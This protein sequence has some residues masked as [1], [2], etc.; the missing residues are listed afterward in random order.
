MNPDH[1]KKY[2]IA[3][4]RVE[5]KKKFYQH[6]T[7]YLTMCIFFMGLAFFTKIGGRWI[8]FPILG[9]GIGILS[10]YFKAFGL[11]GVGPETDWEERA[12]EEELRRLGVPPPPQEKTTETPPP[13][14]EAMTPL[15]LKELQKK[16]DERD[17]V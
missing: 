2:K 9:W 14:E 7:T 3:R 4:E 6:L 16:Y 15:E 10:H 5:E 8:M 12:M 13:E 17:L 11:P 1:D